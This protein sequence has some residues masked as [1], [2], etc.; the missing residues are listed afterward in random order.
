[1]PSA[2]DTDTWQIEGIIKA[3]ESADRVEVVPD[4]VID[5]LF[6]KHIGG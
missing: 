4:E 6:A 3:L 5:P 2:S 1:M